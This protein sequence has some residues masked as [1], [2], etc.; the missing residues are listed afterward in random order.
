MRE[1]IPV[2]AQEVI[3]GL[4]LSSGDMVID[5]TVG[6]GGHALKILERTSPDGKLIGFDRDGRN[7]ELAREHLSKFNNR[8]T[9][10]EDSFANLAEYVKTAVDAVFFDLGYSSLHVDDPTRGFSFKQDGPLD[11]R[12]DRDQELTAQQIVNSWPADDLARLFREYGEEERAGDIA[13]AIVKARRKEQIETT[14]RLAEIV[15]TSKHRSGRLH[16]ATKIFQALRIAVNDEL[17]HVRKGIDAAVDLLKPGGRIVIISFH[18]LEDRI[19]KQR[20]KS[21]SDLKVI[22]KKII[23]PSA[24][25]LAVNPRSRSAK[26]RIAEKI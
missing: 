6:L 18:S 10:I 14:G 4:S 17:G 26:L 20:F 12:Y 2:L 13:K 16:P 19:V 23:K 11:M 7:L 3:D 8:I 25:E 1:H 9:L 24:E 15:E 21:H 5:S 22:T